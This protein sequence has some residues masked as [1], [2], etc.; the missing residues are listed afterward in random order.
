MA[1]GK[2]IIDVWRYCFHTSFLA[3]YATLCQSHFDSGL[4]VNEESKKRGIITQ[5]KVG[6]DSSLHNETL[7]NAFRYETL[8]SSEEKVSCTINQCSFRKI[9]LLVFLYIPRWQNSL[10][11]FFKHSNMLT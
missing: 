5:I 8:P 1:N 4:F 7:A 11:I 6:F 2:D 3:F 9:K 10:C